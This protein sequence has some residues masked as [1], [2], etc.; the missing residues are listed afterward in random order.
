MSVIVQEH[1]ELIWWVAAFSG[2]VF[3]GSLIVVPWLVVRIPA[4][5]FV[6]T[7][8][9]RTAFASQHPLLRWTG[10]IIKNLIGALLIFSGIAMLLLPGQGLLTIA[11][12]ILM[13][14]FPNKHRME[15]RIIRVQPVHKSINWLRQK[16]NVGPLQLEA[17]SMP[18]QAPSSQN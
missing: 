10:L 1:K 12:G 14:D 16:A 8:R 9:P 7:K 6:P 2:F 11:I 13:L 17:E 15:R 4:D 5:Y 18:A 3:V